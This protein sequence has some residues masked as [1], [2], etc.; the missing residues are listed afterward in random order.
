M[1]AVFS[2]SMGLWENFRQL[3][4][5]NNGFSPTDIGNIIS[6]GTLVSVL[7]IFFAG[8]YIKLKNLKTFITCSLVLKFIN[9]IIL[10]C[11]NNMPIRQ[12]N[13]IVNSHNLVIINFNSL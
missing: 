6:V 9:L 7:G 3:W 10:F 11:I 13:N 5:Q 8:K 2:I 1:L 4:L 12:Y